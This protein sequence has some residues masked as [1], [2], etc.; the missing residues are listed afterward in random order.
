MNRTSGWTAS[1]SN[2]MA[3][4]ASMSPCRELILNQ[5]TVGTSRQ[6]KALQAARGVG[7]F[8]FT[9]ST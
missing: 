2:A 8:A 5:V 6:G 4:G 7:W 3:T 9:V 1:M